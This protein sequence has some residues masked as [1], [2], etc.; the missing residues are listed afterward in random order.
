MSS[1][2]GGQGPSPPTGLPST[3]VPLP[4][5]PHPATES[6]GHPFIGSDFLSG[7]PDKGLRGCWKGLG[8]ALPV[9]NWKIF[10]LGSPEL[11]ECA[12]HAPSRREAKTQCCEAGQSPPCQRVLLSC[13]EA[14]QVSGVSSQCLREA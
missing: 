5:R 14:T 6:C 2:R 10:L 7:G 13:E 8:A 1:G 4:A 3:P 12:R 11:T 9:G